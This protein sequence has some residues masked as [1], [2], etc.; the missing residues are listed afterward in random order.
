MFGD[1]DAFAVDF[2]V[3]LVLGTEFED[4]VIAQLREDF[5]DGCC[6]GS[7]VFEGRGESESV[8][9]GVVEGDAFGS[10][11]FAGV[12]GRGFVT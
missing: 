8:W 1:V 4:V 2:D 5:D 6:S 7:G 9:F 3:F 11:H 10:A 12:M